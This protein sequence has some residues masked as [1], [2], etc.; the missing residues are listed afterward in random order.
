LPSRIEAE[1][2]D[3]GEVSVVTENVSR[4]TLDFSGPIFAGRTPGVTVNGRAA[5]PEATEGRP[6]AYAT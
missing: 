2:R 4:F 3:S 1:I 5:E 6:A